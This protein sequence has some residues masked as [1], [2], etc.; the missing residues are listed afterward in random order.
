M[1]VRRKEEEPLWNLVALNREN[2]TL[3]LPPN[4]PYQVFNL[5]EV[6]LLRSGRQNCFLMGDALELCS[7]EAQEAREWLKSIHEFQNACEEGSAAA[8][9]MNELPLPLLSLLEREHQR[10]SALLAQEAFKAQQAEGLLSQEL[11]KE[12]ER[13]KQV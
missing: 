9:S 4:L 2:I 8:V 6:S 12:N 11:A 1:Q 13:R 10:S 5:S 3:S 7:A